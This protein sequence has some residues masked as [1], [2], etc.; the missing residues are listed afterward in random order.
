MNASEEWDTFYVV[1]SNGNIGLKVDQNGVTS[2]EFIADGVELKAAIDNL[3][4]ADSL[5]D[6]AISNLNTK[7]TTDIGAAKEELNAS[8]KSIDVKIDNVQKEL[9][10]NITDVNNT[11]SKSINEVYSTLSETD[12]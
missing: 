5:H 1:D 7:I 2:F 6:E 11:L 9:N 10:Q 3:I 8:I 4:V 12:D